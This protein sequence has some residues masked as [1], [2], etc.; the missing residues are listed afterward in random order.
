M[1]NDN[2]LDNSTKLIINNDN[3]NDINIDNDI[4]NILINIDNE[5]NNID[6]DNNEYNEYNIIL[7]YPE[8]LNNDE[9]LNNSENENIDFLKDLLNNNINNDNDIII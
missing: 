9:I 2:I 8:G 1:N 6:Y 4:N 7:E 3:N 5:I